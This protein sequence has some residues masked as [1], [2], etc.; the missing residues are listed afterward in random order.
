[1]NENSRTIHTNSLPAPSDAW[2][3]R[4][5]SLLILAAVGIVLKP[6]VAPTVAGRTLRQASFALSDRRFSDAARLARSVLQSMPDSRQALLIAGYARAGLH[7]DQG[8]LDYLTRVADDGSGE[9]V[10]ALYQAGVRLV[11]LGRVSQAESNFRRVLELDPLHE[12]AHRQL[13][14]MLQLEGR[15]WES[16]PHL[17]ASVRGGQ[18][19]IG[20]LQEMSDTEVIWR[21]NHEFEDQCLAAVPTDP[22][23]L[24]GRARKALLINNT[25]VALQLFHDIAKLRPDQ[26]QSQAHLGR[27]LLES[28]DDF[29]A[30]HGALPA[31][32]DQHPEIWFTRGLWCDRNGQ[33][34]AAARCFLETLKRHPEHIGAIHHL[35]LALAEQGRTEEADQ[36]ARRAKRLNEVK[37]LLRG[38]GVGNETHQRF[39]NL[40]E[41][42]GRNW[43]AAGSY[44]I[45]LCADPS[46]S[47][48][49]AGLQRLGS[50]LGDGRCSQW[51][52][53]ISRIDLNDA[54]LPNWDAGNSLAANLNADHLNAA[55]SPGAAPA[56]CRVAFEEIAQAAG[57][58][59]QYH[60]G[61]DANQK[62]AYMFEYS[63][64]GVAI[65]DYDDD[66][67]PDIYLTQGCPWP[68]QANQTVYRDRLFR[69]SGDGHFVDVTDAAGLGDNGLSH[70]VTAGDY[71]N[72]GLPDLYV[73]N[74]G[75]NR[76]YE[77]NGDGTFRDVTSASG[78]ACDV[79]SS[80]CVLT[81]FDGDALPDLYVV[82]YLAGPYECQTGNQ[83]TDCGPMSFQAEQDRLFLNLGDGRFRDATG[84]AGVTAEGGKGLGVVAADFDGTGRVS[85]FVANDTTANFYFANQTAN[86]GGKLRFQENAIYRG[87]ACDEMGRTQSCMGVA[88][89]DA[90]GDGLLDLF[91]TNFTRE[92]NALYMQAA[93]SSFVD[94][95]KRAAL[96]DTGFNMMG[97]GTQFMDGEL[98]GLVDLVVAN[99]QLNQHS[100]ER[101]QPQ[102]FR[103]VGGGRFVEATPA[104]LGRY[105]QRGCL[106]RAVARL[107][108][109]RDGLEDLCVTHVDQ[110]TALLVNRTADPGRYL[111]VRL[112]AVHSAADAIGATVRVTAGDQAWTRHLTAGDGFYASNQRLLVFGLGDVEL[113]DSV[114][115]KWPS[116][117]TQEFAT[118][119]TNAEI[120]VIEGRAEAVRLDKRQ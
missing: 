11:G 5:A 98:D 86:R 102:Y 28:N 41:S 51:E 16:L 113:L 55:D 25:P 117:E 39:A 111:A 61:A 22:L 27:L 23:P 3:A 116:G 58:R 54:P 7:D 118:M 17:F 21:S 106:G 95:I 65:L 78:T 97:W 45:A 71:I 77:N 84:E 88:A 13:G 59:F 57:I 119:E 81:D 104:T 93:D 1:M 108:L 99:G 36:L 105:F 44:Y 38:I 20:N 101:M 14:I 56:A 48:A 115:V 2:V 92:A 19:T 32:A 72:D 26:L 52:A 120:L 112:R 29:L 67:W 82:N 64:G 6:V 109:N 79:W 107:D 42:L 74:I 89:G 8:A 15:S 94:N 62:Q 73:A 12:E 80:S 30:W 53:A 96:L 37:V 60:N 66:G 50:R 68:T 46:N 87:L 43:E 91:V 40:L 75:P 69:N 18:F 100:P 49:R 83:P 10:V 110:P 47:W 4:L 90:N 114:T 34:L 24:L 85:L 31:S 9:A 35:G 33:P 103:N 63:G 76:L 70:G